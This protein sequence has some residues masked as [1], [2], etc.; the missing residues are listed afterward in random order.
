MVLRRRLLSG[1]FENRIDP[2]SDLGGLFAAR[3]EVPTRRDSNRAFYVI[4]SLCPLP[5]RLPGSDRPITDLVWN[6]NKM[7]VR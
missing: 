3:Q 5:S 2:S 4:N 1:L 6:T 7:T